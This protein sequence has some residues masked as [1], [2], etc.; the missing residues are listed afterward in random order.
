MGNKELTCLFSF[1]QVH[2]LYPVQ[3]TI[4]KSIPPSKVY[5]IISTLVFKLW[6]TILEI[7]PDKPIDTHLFKCLKFYFLK[8]AINDRVSRAA[9]SSPPVRIPRVSGQK[10]GSVNQTVVKGIPMAQGQT[11]WI[12]VHWHWILLETVFSTLHWQ[13]NGCLLPPT[14][15][16]EIHIFVNAFRF[17]L[18]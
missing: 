13:C 12:Y 18:T 16:E 4:T 9:D 14:L 1:C 5:V 2:F 11:R 6:L 15:Q 7:Q 17:I 3:N 8:M 10:Q